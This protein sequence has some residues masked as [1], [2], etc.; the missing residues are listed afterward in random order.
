MIYLME[1]PK[2]TTV[3][4]TLTDVS[5][6]NKDPAFDEYLPY[7]ACDFYQLLRGSRGTDIQTKGRAM[8]NPPNRGSCPIQVTQMNRR[9]P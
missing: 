8:S 6:G 3:R 9:L 2:A 5:G 4:W 7:P 1:H